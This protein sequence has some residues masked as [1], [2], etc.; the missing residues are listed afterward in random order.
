M[1]RQ[2][3]VHNCWNSCKMAANGREH[4]EVS[5]LLFSVP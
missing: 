2:R 1:R 5:G 3:Q 4:I